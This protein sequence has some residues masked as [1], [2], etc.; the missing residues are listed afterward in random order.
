LT[1]AR[2]KSGGFLSVMSDG[3]LNSN[4]DDDI[5]NLIERLNS[6][7]NPIDAIIYNSGKKGVGIKLN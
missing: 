6:K 4:M 2:A 3:V 1:K 5:N 7:K